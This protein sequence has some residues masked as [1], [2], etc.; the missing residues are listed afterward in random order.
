M[1]LLDVGGRQITEV[2]LALYF[3]FL[4]SYSLANGDAADTKIKHERYEGTAAYFRD[5]REA[6]L[7]RDLIA[8]IVSL[9]FHMYL[10]ECSH[11]IA[12]LKCVVLVI[13]MCRN[14][15]GG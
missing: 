8:A 14:C 3:M 2:H 7:L 5:S 10:E 6:N 4:I 12:F 11:F 15:A 9:Y 13:N 1:S